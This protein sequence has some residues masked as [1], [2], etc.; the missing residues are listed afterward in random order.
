MCIDRRFSKIRSHILPVFTLMHSFD[1]IE[2]Q[3]IGLVFNRLLLN[4]Q[5]I[6][7]ASIFYKWAHNSF[8]LVATKLKLAPNCLAFWMVLSVKQ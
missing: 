5:Y 7:K 1:G 2:R 6:A 3:I 4:C 8:V